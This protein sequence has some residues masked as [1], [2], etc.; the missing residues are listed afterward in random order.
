MTTD[1]LIS[2]I[3][4]ST[5]QMVRELGLLNNRF[6]TI[7][8]ASQCHALVELDSHGVLN[9]G[10]LSTILNLE[11]STVSRLVTHLHENG[12]C[13]IQSDAN[14]RR[15][16]LISLTKKGQ[17][18]ANEIHFA[19]KL[20]VN[21]ALEMMNED[22]RNIVVQGI[23]LYAKALRKSGIQN[24]YTIRKLLKH[25]VPQ[26]IN[27]IKS[28]RAEFGF[29]ASHPQAP[30]F[31]EELKN[32]YESYTGKNREYYVLTHDDKIVGGAG[33]GAISS[34]E[35]N[36]CE[37][38]GMYLSQQLRGLGLGSKLLKRVLEEA[39]NRGF[40]KCYLETNDFM[41]GANTLYMK[42]GFVKLAKPIDGAGH[43]CTNIWYIKK[44]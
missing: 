35:K 5:R 40:K 19:A 7:G 44:L 27:I 24:E 14:D 4:A 43:A 31:E 23:S 17:A 10:Q 18:L 13:D 26:L 12:L 39:V 32:L 41:H 15:N 6:A 42:N 9:S 34:P 3:R 8:S 22:E 37:L 21:Q 36:I 28:V 16:K 30:L 29:D 2:Q 1:A 11:K 33:F 25:D 38:K 20:Q